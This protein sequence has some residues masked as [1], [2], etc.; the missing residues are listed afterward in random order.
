[1]TKQWHLMICQCGTSYGIR[2]GTSRSCIR[3]GSINSRIVSEFH[4]SSELASAVSLA[5][6]PPEIAKEIESK[7]SKKDE[8]Q[9][10]NGGSDLSTSKF[11]RAMYDATNEDGILE[12][13]VLQRILDE[14][15]IVDPSAEYLIGQAELEGIIIRISAKSWS[16]L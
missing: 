9:T 2:K 12:D 8:L 3:C 10:T 15:K 14:R 16:W 7:I 11:L 13:S 1:M 4:T 6:M 5:N